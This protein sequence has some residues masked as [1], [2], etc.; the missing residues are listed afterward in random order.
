ML[1]SMSVHENIGI[2][3]FDD[4]KSE[5]NDLEVA[6]EVTEYNDQ[7]HFMSLDWLVPTGII[8]FMAK[9][10]FETIL[11]KMA[12]DHYELV[13]KAFKD[14]LYKKAIHPENYE[15]EL[16]SNG[17]TKDSYFTLH[18]SIETKI[19]DDEGE[20]SVRLMFPKNCDEEYFSQAINRFSEFISSYTMKDNES[21][22]ATKLMNLDVMGRRWKKIVWF[23]E[24]SGDIEW[25][26]VV[27][28][29]KTKK[30]ITSTIT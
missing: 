4:F 15:F 20:L 9:P 26:D 18:F 14:L 24:K 3:E 28:S 23:N 22:L 8:L 1:L 13:K 30:L 27:N 21:E 17:K 12:E 25:V 29:A 16:V 5:I 6:L 11:K 7:G 10:Y 2:E 19:T